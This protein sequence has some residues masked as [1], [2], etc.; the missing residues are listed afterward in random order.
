MTPTAKQ[1]ADHPPAIEGYVD[2][3]M[4]RAEFI[5]RA[6]AYLADVQAWLREN[7]PRLSG[8]VALARFTA[9]HDALIATALRHE[10]DSYK[11]RH[12]GAA[13]Q[14]SLMALGGY[15][16]R[17]L[18]L[19]SDIDLLFL[20]CEPG[21]ECED[22]IK[23]L[24]H[25]LTDCKLRMST[26]ARTPAQCLERVGHDLDSTT[27]LLEGRLIAGAK[28]PAEKLMT[29]LRKRITGADRRWFLGAVYQQ[30]KQRREKYEATVYLLEPNLKEGEGGLRD[31]HSVQWVLDAIAGSSDIG[32]LT[33]LAGIEAATLEK[34]RDAID[35]LYTV[36]N[37]LH[38]AAGIKQDRLEFAYQPAIAKRLGYEADPLYTAEERF[39]GFYYQHARIIAGV[40]SRAM[41]ELTRRQ[42]WLAK[43]LYGPSKR[44]KLSDGS[45]IER[46][47]LYLSPEAE[48][49]LI[50]DP[51]RLMALFEKAAL[52]GWRMSESALE[53]LGRVSGGL[54]ESFAADKANCR[55]FMQ[56]LGSA[57]AI[58][59]TIADM[60]ECGALE[61]L[62]PEFE[63]VRA[64]VR[65]D[66]YHH[67]TVD[68]HLI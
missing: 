57:A 18:S 23:P 48:R 26:V 52:H 16:R 61:L 22:L 2:A 55:R 3:S 31:V 67:Y 64:M 53:I 60:H 10:T 51:H 6:Q 58:D 25:L 43:E 68:E 14:L 56:I 17:A 41:R 15:G 66:H 20:M 33:E 29:M 7:N 50:G 42:P 34:F 45:W 44:R 12:K 4:A 32:A 27:A 19:L 49:E 39:M 9:A 13:P 21:P 47:V 40:S 63:Q 30:W 38:A 24:L 37:E 65:I 8:R 28:Q 1:R 54:G 36:R 35:T 11:E 46:D 62:I 59:Q 5:S